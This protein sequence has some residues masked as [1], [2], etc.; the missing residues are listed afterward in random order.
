VFN[1]QTIKHWSLGGLG[2]LLPFGVAKAGQSVRF[3][4]FANEN[5]VT[6]KTAKIL[7]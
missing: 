1:Y 4:D 6:P 5:H 2:E 7:K 3:P